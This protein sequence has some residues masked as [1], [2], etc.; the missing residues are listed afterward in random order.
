MT[1]YESWEVVN[2]LVANLMQQEA[3]FIGSL[4]AYV[5]AA[6][7]VGKTLT[8]FQILFIS[9]VFVMLSLLGIQSQLWF[10]GNIEEVAR[11]IAGMATSQETSDVNFSIGFV[12]E[13]VVLMLGALFY[14]WQVR[15]PKTE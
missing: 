14:M 7:W 11:G 15:H 1:E 6:H 9:I 10:I 8:T 2:G 5:V 4:T 3:L 12:V 13:R